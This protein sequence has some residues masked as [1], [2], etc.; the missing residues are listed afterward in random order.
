MVMMVLCAAPARAQSTEAPAA[1]GA[2][3][4]P[5]KLQLLL[6]TEIALHSADMISTA[7]TLQLSGSAREGNPLLARFSNHPAALIAI[8]GG[9][10][11]LQIYTINKVSRRHP[12][13]AA[14]WALILIGTE[15]YAVA[16][17]LTLASQLR[18]ARAG[19]R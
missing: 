2:P 13:L 18:D 17:N 11:L 3:D 7:Y 9:V 4:R 8:S 19:T 6:A 15:S 1:N 16:H 14:A 10:N 5:S 12:K